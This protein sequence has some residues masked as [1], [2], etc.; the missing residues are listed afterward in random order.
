M[1]FAIATLGCKV[2][3]YDSALIESRLGSLGMVRGDFN[4]PADV[5]VVNTCTVTDRADAESLLAYAP[6]TRIAA[7]MSFSQL[8]TPA[9]EVGM[10]RM[11][12]ELIDRIV[13]IEGAFYLPYRLHACRDQVAKAYPK[14]DEFVAKKRQYDPHLLF[15]NALWET[16]FAA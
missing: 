10:M 5:Y 12:E 11:T 3:Q 2:N 7:V 16:Y 8:M 9:G 15:R 13:S 1:R 4:Q 14:A 6:V